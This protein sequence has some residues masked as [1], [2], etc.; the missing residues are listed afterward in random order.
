MNIDKERDGEKKKRFDGKDD[1]KE[2]EKEVVERDGE[3]MLRG[4][5]VSEKERYEGGMGAR[6]ERRDGKRASGRERGRKRKMRN[7][8]ERDSGRERVYVCVCV[9]LQLCL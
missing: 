8:R 5:S 2:E 6:E 9:Q 7:G 4:K 3:G 1:A